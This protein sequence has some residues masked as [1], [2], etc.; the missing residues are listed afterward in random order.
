[1]FSLVKVI[2][3]IIEIIIVDHRLKPFATMADVNECNG[4]LWTCF[5]CKATFDRKRSLKYHQNI[6]LHHFKGNE[7]QKDNLHYTQYDLKLLTR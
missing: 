2:A 5:R 4:S 3:T 6:C 1:M 7:P